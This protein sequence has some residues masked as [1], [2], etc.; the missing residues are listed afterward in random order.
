MASSIDWASSYIP[1]WRLMRV[2]PTTWADCAVIEEFVSGSVDRDK[3]GNAIESGSF[4]VDGSLDAF[5]GRLEMVADQDGI[6]EI[7]PVATLWLEPGSVTV[8]NHRPLQSMTGYSVLS[9][10][11][12]RVFQADTNIFRGT[13][14]AAK[15][16][17]LIAECTPAP[18]RAVG[19]FSIDEHTAITAGTTYLDAAWQLVDAAGWCI[20]VSGSG[21]VTVGPVPSEPALVIDG[22]T[23]GL[24][25]GEVET[26]TVIDSLPNRYIAVD[27]ERVAVAVDDDPDSP[28]STVARGRFVDHFD[29]SPQ[30][31]DGEGLQ[32]YARRRLAE[33]CEVVG[34]KSYRR[35]WHPDVTCFDLVCGYLP[36]E[37]LD[38]DMRVKSQSIGTDSPLS[39]SET[40]EVIA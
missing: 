17:S 8:K 25:E 10:A 36:Q 28:T 1:N 31:V 13:D 15:A 39:I 37:D 21:E 22:S 12:E 20:Q 33:E 9:R 5:W 32:A 19:S 11:S 16:A 38:C 30:R 24:L 40:C 29:N 2:E 4:D 7:H 27:G 23:A 18:V 6:V 14:G 26:E 35:G 34:T 3:G